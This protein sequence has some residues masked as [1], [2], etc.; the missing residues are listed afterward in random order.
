MKRILGYASI[1][2]G[3]ASLLALSANQPATALPMY[4]QRSGRSCAN[5]HV[6]PTLEDSEGWENP[7][8]AQRKCSLSCVTC[9]VN[10]TGGGLRNSSGRYYGQSTLAM[11]GTQD[12]DYS[13]HDREVLDNDRLWRYK[14]KHGEYPTRE[15]GERMIPSNYDDVKAGMGAGQT[16]NRYVFGEPLGTEGGEEP[17]EMAFWDGRYDDLNADPLVQFGADLRGAYWSGSETAFPMQ[18]DLHGAIHPVEHVTAMAT[19]AARG[20]TGGIADTVAD[21]Q[22][23]VFARNAFVMLHE[24][25]YMSFARAGYFMPSFGTYIDD[26]TSFTREMFEM[27]VSHSEDRALGVEAGFAANYPYGQASVFLNDPMGD[28]GWGASFN[29][30]MR[31]LG[32]TATGHG[33]IK[34][35]GGEGRGDLDAFGVGWGFNPFYYSNSL[36]FTLMGEVNVGKRTLGVNEV[37][38]AATQ[39]ELWWTIR[40]GISARGKVDLGVQDLSAA[41][42][43]QRYQLGLEVGIVPGVTMTGWVRQLSTPGQVAARDYLIMSHL[44]F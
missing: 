28:T 9:H 4:A 2:V 3:G 20:R 31:E 18:I 30:G 24:L 1:A 32:W 17:A 14:D 7:D 12:R 44:W 39:A 21:P 27:N 40:N 43:Q 34:R 38:F 16:G 11:L 35:R 22:G 36:P 6:S 5:C 25:P 13:D 41:V 10:P 33:M 37:Q 26:H 15:E 29:G 19:A 8:L 23:P 42:L